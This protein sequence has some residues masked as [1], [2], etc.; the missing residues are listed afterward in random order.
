MALSALR[1]E[2]CLS[3]VGHW[4]S[5]NRLQ[6]NTDKTELLWA[7]SRRSCPLLA[8]LLPS[9]T[10]LSTPLALTVSDVCLK[11]GCFKV[12]STHSAYCT[13]WVS[14]F[15]RYINSTYSLVGLKYYKLKNTRL[16]LTECPFFK[17]TLKLHGMHLIL[18]QTKSSLAQTK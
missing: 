2:C 9:S 16:R 13:L 5:S 6:L 10:P 7:G 14:H 11:L 8:L 3:E 1:L 18:S 4:M 12:T 17:Q 15:M